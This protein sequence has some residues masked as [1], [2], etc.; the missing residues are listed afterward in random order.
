MPTY[1][2]SRL[3]TLEQCPRRYAFRYREKPDIVETTSVEAFLGSR[4]HEALE[5]LYEDVVF[6]RV[7]S[8]DHVATEF[9][10]LWDSCWRDDV[11]ITRDA[12]AG[13]YRAIGEKMVRS[14]VDRYAPFDDGQTIGTEMRVDAALDGP[15]DY[16]L[17]GYV[18]RVVR[19]APGHWR[20]HDYKT[21]RS[22][23]TQDQLDADRQLALYQI[24]L[25]GMYPEV[26]SV[27]LVWHYLAFDMELRSVRTP[28]QLEQLRSETIRRIE[29]AE[30]CTEFPTRA[31]ALC[32]WCEYRAICPAQAHERRA[33]AQEPEALDGVG[34]VDAYVDL[35]SRIKELEFEKDRVGRDLTAYAEANGF[36]VV[37]GTEQQVK[38]WRKD[39][40]CTLPAWDDPRRAEIECV[41]REAGLWDRFSSLATV[42]LSKAIEEGSLPSDVVEALLPFA[43][44]ETRTRLYPRGRGGRRF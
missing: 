8:A 6:G 14:Y 20:I 43:T 44:I 32:A 10:R 27:E 12:T 16:R 22:L 3:E 5:W 35:G 25:H 38:V 7:P 9:L 26:E 21:G 36:D 24:A 2:Y 18:D 33:R 31:G 39:N 15:G 29:A 19:V 1:S 34:L 4:V 37:V 41:L 23:P 11:A 30:A 42:G 17:I 28:D 40:A 13:E